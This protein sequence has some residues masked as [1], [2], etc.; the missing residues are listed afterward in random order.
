MK[1]V[2]IKFGLISGAISAALML[3]TVPFIYRIGFDKGVYVGYSGMLLS[4]LLVFFGVRSYR[5]NVLDGSISFF[6][7]LLV[8]L[9]ITFISTACYVITWE[10]VYFNILPDFADKYTAY[11]IDSMQR[12]GKSAQE[13]AAATEQMK[14]LKVMLNNPFLNAL[15]TFTEPLPVG[16]FVTIVSAVVLR[17]RP[18][19]DQKEQ[20][21]IPVSN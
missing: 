3:A 8:G 16:L 12:S 4:F 20:T 7:A 15:L 2:V 13:I 6:R 10:F 18:Q 19:P 21:P 5:D 17:R 14:Q 11:A 1:K 9:L